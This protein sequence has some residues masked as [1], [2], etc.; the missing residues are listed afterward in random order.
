M[1][2]IFP[3]QEVGSKTVGPPAIEL[4]GRYAYKKSGVMD[5]SLEIWFE[6]DGFFELEYMEKSDDGSFST[7]NEKG[8]YVITDKGEK[9]GKIGISLEPMERNWKWDDGEDG[10]SGTDVVTILIQI[11]MRLTSNTPQLFQSNL[12]N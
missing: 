2:I 10:D 7:N 12:R 5:V 6:K 3:K 1:E 8:K 11:T 4:H 9:T